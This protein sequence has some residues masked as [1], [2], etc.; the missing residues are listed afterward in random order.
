MELVEGRVDDAEA[1]LAGLEAVREEYGVV[2]QAVDARLVAGRKHLAAAVE[3]ADR[4]LERGET[5]ADDPAVELLLYAAGRRQIDRALEMGVGDGTPAVVVVDGDDAAGAADAV[6][7]LLDP[8][9]AGVA[10][11]AGD[12]AAIRDFF[13]VPAAELEAAAGGLAD[14][15]RERVALL[16]VEK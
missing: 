6:A 14:L 1:F 2:A 5:V 13:D 12:R 3:H 7:D 16:D 4:A 8:A 11:A 9:E 15:V 10:L